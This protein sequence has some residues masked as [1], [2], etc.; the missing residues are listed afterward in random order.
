MYLFDKESL[1]IPCYFPSSNYA[2]RSVLIISIAWEAST[3]VVPGEQI[4]IALLRLGTR[5][6]QPGDRQ[7]TARSLAG[8]AA[9]AVPAR[10][11]GALSGGG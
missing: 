2:Y 10:R 8:D 11:L 9:R 5:E 3:G 4:E 1:V 6:R 7:G